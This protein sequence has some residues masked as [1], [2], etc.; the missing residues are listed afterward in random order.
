MLIL[1]QYSW[2]N[3]KKFNFIK[4]LWASYFAIE[5]VLNLEIHQICIR[6]RVM[7][8]MENFVPSYIKFDHY[9]RTSHI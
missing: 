5:G 7:D 2:S 4:I 3:F 9:I 6:H 8:A 1:F